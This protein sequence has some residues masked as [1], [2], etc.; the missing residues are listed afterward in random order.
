MSKILRMLRDG[1]GYTFRLWFTQEEDYRWQLAVDDETALA[2]DWQVVGGDLSFAMKDFEVRN[3][4]RLH[5]QK[6]EETP[7]EQLS[8]I[9]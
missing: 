7:E 8:L 6:E 2:H 5:G 3:W 9:P 4:N 1:A